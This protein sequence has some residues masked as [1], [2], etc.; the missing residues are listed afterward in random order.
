M[1][2]LFKTNAD[3]LTMLY[4]SAIILS[5]SVFLV[6]RF[7]VSAAI[8]FLIAALEVGSIGVLCTDAVK[9]LIVSKY[10]IS[11]GQTRHYSLVNSDSKR[12][13]IFAALGCIVSMTIDVITFGIA[14]ALIL[15]FSVLIGRSL[16]T[17]EIAKRTLIS[18]MTEDQ[19]R[20][21][22][23]VISESARLM[24]DKSS[25]ST[26]Q[27]LSRY[28]GSV[29]YCVNY[30]PIDLL[31][32]DLESYDSREDLSLLG[33]L[34][35]IAS[36]RSTERLENGVLSNAIHSAQDKRLESFEDYRMYLS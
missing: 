14:A 15:I 26:N 2:H 18:S 4:V 1:K 12:I 19:K 9:D 23:R 22:Y 24:S 3:K 21:R 30:L 13:L 36:A 6:S 20:L 28:I 10:F 31:M 17:D 33:K 29:D 8:E 7:A 34:S 5:I 35:I 16:A 11:K 25:N 27:Q 32:K